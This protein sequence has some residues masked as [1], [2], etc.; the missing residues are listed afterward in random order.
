MARIEF[1]VQIRNP[2]NGIVVNEARIDLTFPDTAIGGTQDLERAVKIAYEKAVQALARNA[3]AIYV[4]FTR[5]RHG[6][7]AHVIV[8][9]S[10]S[11]ESLEQRFDQ[12]RLLVGEELD[13][14]EIGERVA[15]VM[16][17]WLAQQGNA[18]YIQSSARP[19]AVFHD[20]RAAD[21]DR[22]TTSVVPRY[23]ADCISAAIYNPDNP[24]ERPCMV[25]T[26]DPLFAARWCR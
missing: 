25:Y 2:Q 12:L 24:N 18:D 13:D 14:A 23:V 15:D 16:V 5:S 20:A 7:H 11:F 3:N 8:T 4:L 17:R 21:A 22:L 10:A 6:H 19:I 26:L 9:R 1:T